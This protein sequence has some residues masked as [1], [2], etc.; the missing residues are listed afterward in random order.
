M[1]QLFQ[2]AFFVSWKVGRCVGRRKRTILQQSRPATPFE[3]NTYKIC[4]QRLS[5]Y[6]PTINYEKL[7]NPDFILQNVTWARV[8]SCRIKL[9]PHAVFKKMQDTTHHHALPK[10]HSH[11]SNASSW[12]ANFKDIQVTYR[13]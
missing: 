11:Y 10:K 8:S 4:A 1:Q 5:C 2:E 12:K 6:T 7:F 13:N 3:S 9:S